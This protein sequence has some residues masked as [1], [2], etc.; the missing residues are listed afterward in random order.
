MNKKTL[1]TCILAATWITQV[2]AMNFD[3]IS[4]DKTPAGQYQVE[5]THA[6]ITFSYLHLGFS[7][8][9]LQFTNFDIDFNFKPEDIE[10]SDVKLTIY[11]NSIKS[12][13]EV[14][15]Q[16]LREKEVFFE[17]E[18]ISNHGLSQQENF[19]ICYRPVSY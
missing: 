16:H 2:Q 1:I 17:S 9:I 18:K 4:F 5:K 14:F 10:N 3:T 6:Y 13:V 11:T 19:S 7:N 15:D 12:G 8:P